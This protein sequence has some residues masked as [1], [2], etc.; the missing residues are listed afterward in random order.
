MKVETLILRITDADS[1]YRRSRGNVQRHSDLKNRFQIEG[2][3]SPAD[4][5]TY[6]GQR[7][8][9]LRRVKAKAVQTSRKK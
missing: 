9:N 8:D 2:V 1:F 6:G 5:S 7:G 3:S 4:S